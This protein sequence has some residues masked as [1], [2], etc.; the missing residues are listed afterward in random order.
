MD[1]ILERREEHT[2]LANTHTEDLCVGGVAALLNDMAK[3]TLSDADLMVL[4]GFVRKRLMANIRQIMIYG[5]MHYIDMC[6][7]LSHT[8]APS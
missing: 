6:P 2:T 5:H 7:P 1:C 8:R 4:T 3:L